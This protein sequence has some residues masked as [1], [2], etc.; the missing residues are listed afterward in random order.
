MRSKWTVLAGAILGICVGTARAADPAPLPA[1]PGAEGFGATVTGGRGGEVYH[2]TNLN[3]NGP[4]SFRDAVSKPNRTVVFDVGGV[5]KMEK[6]IVVNDNITIAGQTAPG[7]GICLYG[8][9]L[10][11][12][13]H[14]NVIVRYIR[15][16]QGIG[17]ARGNCSIRVSSGS[18]MIFDHCSIQWGRWDCI[19]F[20]VGTKNLTLQYCM[21][22]EGLDPQRFGALI[23]TVEHVTIS[24]TL[25]QSLHSR[26]P[27]AK[28]TIQYINNVVYNWQITGLV[29][30]HSAADHQL[31]VI[32]NYFIAGPASNKQAVGFFTKTDHV[33]SSGNLV[34][35]N[36]DGVLNGVPVVEADYND[37]KDAPTFVPALWG[38]PAIPVTV[39]SAEKAYEKVVASVGC[40]LHRDAVDL[41]LI[42]E[43]KSLG[44]KGKIIDKEA[45]AGGL[46]EIK[47]GPAPKDT[48]NDGIPDA[49]ESVHG[50]NPNDAADGNKLDKSGY[51]NLEI[52]MNSLVNVPGVKPMM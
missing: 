36:K 26:N 44:K 30:G 51:T 1:F 39:D 22:G 28:G 49:W 11:L 5:I 13:N 38:N 3:D 6:N 45:D 16:R 33:Y 47:G 25:W 10:T 48:D 32:N 41:R 15:I 46:S 14:H 40:S 50:L 43:V 52:Y 42:D 34:D 19:G 17:G 9:E 4:G 27:K 21:M 20:T 35:Q 37:N 24:H 12:S 31:D 29:G 7:E 23:D 18:D 8:N 2:V